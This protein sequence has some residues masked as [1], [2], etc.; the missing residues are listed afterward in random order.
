M[1]EQRDIP[2]LRTIASIEGDPPDAPAGGEAP[3]LSGPPAEST[4]TGD[5]PGRVFTQAEVDSIVGDRLRRDRTARAQVAPA[6]PAPAPPP[7][8]T[9]TPQDMAAE[10]AAIKAQLA[11]SDTLSTLPEAARLSLEQRSAL[12]KLFDPSNP[13]ALA[14]T[15]RLFAPIPAPAAEPSAPAATP[16]TPFVAGGSAPAAPPREASLD[17]LTWTKSDIEA[18]QQRGEFRSNLD[19]WRNSL[20]GGAPLFTRRVPKA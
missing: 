16:P 6:A 20:P 18:M 13:E 10:L 8:K 19:K 1:L 5:P 14:D 9:Q 2:T 3:P 4:P 12:R 17:P 11:F 15:V 7:A